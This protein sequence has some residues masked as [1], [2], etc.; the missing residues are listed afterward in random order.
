LL[1]P[2]S[3]PCPSSLVDGLYT[4]A[5]EAWAICAIPSSRG[6]YVPV[7]SC[8]NEVAITAADSGTRRT[9]FTISGSESARP[10]TNLKVR[11]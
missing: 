3:R 5:E 8:V 10:S 7:P 9:S 11:S 1:V 4:G 6:K 2:A